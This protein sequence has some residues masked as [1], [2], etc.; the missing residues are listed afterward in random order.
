MEPH[1]LVE[2]FFWLIVFVVGGTIADYLH[3][4]GYV[5]SF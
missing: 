1:H 4:A 2:A 5:I 3:R